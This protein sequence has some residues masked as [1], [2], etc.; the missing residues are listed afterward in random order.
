MTVETPVAFIFNSDEE[1][2]QLFKYEF[3]NNALPTSAYCMQKPAKKE[4]YD[5]IFLYA[6]GV[7]NFKFNIDLSY[8]KDGLDGY[9]QVP[10]DTSQSMYSTRSLI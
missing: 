8:S 5:C 2:K 9:L 1:M 4:L 7:P 10:I 6:S 3:S